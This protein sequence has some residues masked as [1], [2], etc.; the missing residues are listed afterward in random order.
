MSILK[1]PYNFVPLSKQVVRPEWGAC[2][3]HDL[4]FEDGVSGTFAL[5]IKAES[6]IFTRNSISR[7]ITDEGSRREA[8]AKFSAFLEKFFIPGSSI[9]GSIRNVFEIMTFG[10]FASGLVDRPYA[11]RDLEVES[12]KEMFSL[13]GGEKVYCGWLKRR[14]NKDEYYIED[15]GFPQRITHKEIDAYFG[16]SILKN[17]V[18]GFEKD[19]LNKSKK[20]NFSKGTAEIKASLFS[21]KPFHGTYTLSDGS[22][23][24]GRLVFTGQPSIKFDKTTKKGTLDVGTGESIKYKEFIF[25]DVVEEIDVDD[26][27]VKAFE[28]AYGTLHGRQL[29]HKPVFFHKDE[30]GKVKSLGQA[31]MYKIPFKNSVRE[32]TQKVQ[33]HTDLPDFAECVFGHLG[34]T[35]L[36]G[37]VIFGHAWAQGNPQPLALKAEVLNSPKPTYYPT[38]V[39]QSVNTNGRT[40]NYKTFFDHDAEPVGWKRYPVHSDG[41]K[42]NPGPPVRDNSNIQ[43]RFRPLAEGTE[44]NCT[45]SFHNLRKVELGALLSSILFHETPD[46]FHSLGM[47]KPLGYGKCSI[48]ISG[49][50][51]TLRNEAIADFEAYMEHALKDNPGG[52]AKSEAIRELLTMSSIQNNSNERSKLEYMADVKDFAKAKREKQALAR[53]AK[54]PGIQPKELSTHPGGS[55][56]SAIDFSKCHSN[57]IPQ[58]EKFFTQMREEKIKLIEQRIDNLKKKIEK[59][60]L[61]AQEEAERKERLAKQQRMEEEDRI[62]NL[63]YGFN[64]NGILPNNT[65]DGTIR[66]LKFWEKQGGKIGIAEVETIIDRFKTLGSKFSNDKKKVEWKSQC[67]KQINKLNSLLNEES[68]SLIKN[69]VE[70][71]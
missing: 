43:T 40:N 57:P 8:G 15:C 27:V 48:S 66:A 23:V 71:I 1:A 44:F 32:A 10:N 4:P 21:G 41:V 13:T 52:W 49:L 42:T 69:V 47:A 5:R 58:L 29:N 12:Y 61:E 60:R 56:P 45:V 22:S 14:G 16:G 17:W 26:D 59:E 64:A 6:P 7:R 31:Y 9:K 54:L 65:I 62:R 51:E 20:Y 3:S 36:K 18:E 2:I 67:L 53:Y 25:P 37:R 70:D 55:L 19:T 38:Y 24:T 68:F 28:F 50:D 34:D 39:K 35:P 30:N 33:P 63:D 46:C 11:M